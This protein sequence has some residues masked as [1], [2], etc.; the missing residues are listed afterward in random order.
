MAVVFGGLL[1]LCFTA[2]QGGVVF[3][4]AY[5]G[6]AVLKTSHPKAKIAAMAASWTFWVLA[7]LFGYALLGGGGGLMEGFGLIL[8]LCG[9]ATIG[10]LAYLILWTVRASA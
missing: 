2:A 7:T 4:A 9:T 5:L 3:G 10:S 6:L 1:L 8:F